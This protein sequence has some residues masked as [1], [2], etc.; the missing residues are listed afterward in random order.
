MKRIVVA[1]LAA[2]T[3]AGTVAPTLAIDGHGNAASPERAVPN[4]GNVS[5]GP[6][7]RDDPCVREAQEIRPDGKPVHHENDGHAHGHS[8][9]RK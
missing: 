7:H 5:G 2:G 3:L 1:I 4:T 8:H 9:G 6:A